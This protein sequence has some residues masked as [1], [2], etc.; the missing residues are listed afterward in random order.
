MTDRV[1]AE[2]I[3]AFSG[4]ESD[5]MVYYDLCVASEGTGDVTEIIPAE[6]KEN[7]DLIN[8]MFSGFDYDLAGLNVTDTSAQESPS[9]KGF[10]EQLLDKWAAYTLPALSDDSNNF[11]VQL[12]RLVEANSCAGN[13][14]VLDSTQCD[15]DQESTATSTEK[16]GDGESSSYCLIV[17]TFPFNTLVTR[18]DPLS[19]ASASRVE[20]NRLKGAVEQHDNL[21]VEMKD[22]LVVPKGK[23][24]D[25]YAAIFD[26][27]DDIETF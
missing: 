5:L 10:E 13:N 26:V 17:P 23:A 25:L 22:A 20:Y 2:K 6:A 15:Q 7:F 18:W 27:K 3:I 12:V 19:C 4:Q 24:A 9:M 1:Y 11:E 21:L 16:E 8:T 14:I